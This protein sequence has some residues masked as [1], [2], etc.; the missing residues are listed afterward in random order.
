MGNAA[1]ARS[2]AASMAAAVL[3]SAGCQK[4]P[5]APPPPLQAEVITVVPR[6]VPIYQEWIGTMDGYVTAQIR[7]QVSGYLMSRNYE[8]GSVVKQG[9]LLFQIDPRPFQATLD[10]AK[11]RLGQDQAQ[12]H[13][14]QL[15]VERDT[16]LAREGAVSQ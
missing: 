1:T 9:D 15:D 4:K 13:K 14:T 3:F 6:D 11:G 2:I 8:E 16:P 7:P 12:H 10:Q 5:A